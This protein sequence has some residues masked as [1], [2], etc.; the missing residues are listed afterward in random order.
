MVNAMSN[1]NL[2]IFHQKPQIFAGKVVQ[3]LK[4]M[5]TLIH[6]QLVYNNQPILLVVE[7]FVLHHTKNVNSYN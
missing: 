6:F 7:H 4:R 5:M 1:A 3:S 2:A